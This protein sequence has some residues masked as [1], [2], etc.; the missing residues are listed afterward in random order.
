MS[1]KKNIPPKKAAGKTLPLE[2]V[3]AAKNDLTRIALFLGAAV[4][5][6]YICFINAFKADFTNWD[7]VQYVTESTL[8]KSLHW[9]NIKT[10]FT[11]RSV[12]GNYH[13][14][15]VLSLALDYHSGKLD[16]H[17]FHTTSIIIHLLN[18][19]LVFLFIQLLVKQPVIS[20]IT[21][22]LFGISPMH[23]ESVA[24]VAERKDVLYVFFYMAS[25][26]A[27]LFYLK[28]DKRKIL[29]IVLAF[30]LFA[31]SLLSKAQAVMLPF[32]L[33]GIDYFKGRKFELKIILEK[34]PFFL[35]A[36]LMGVIAVV[37]QKETGAIK[38]IPDNTLLERIAFAGYSFMAYTI[39]LIY[40]GSLSAYYPYPDRPYSIIYIV[41]ALFAIVLVSLVIKNYKNKTLVL[42]AGFYV[43]NIVLLLQLLPVGGAMMADRYSYLCSVGLFFI[44]GKYAFDLLENKK[45]ASFK[46]ALMAIMIGYGSYLAYGARE[47]TKVWNNSKLLWA[48]VLKQYQNAPI[49]YNQLGSYYQKHKSLDTALAYFNEAIRLKPLF[50]E[51]LTNRSDIFR[52]RGD[53]KQAIADCDSAI[54]SDVNYTAAYM[55]RGIAYCFVGK[56]DDALR[57]FTFVVSKKA[58]EASLY[59]NRGN[60]YDMK[61]KIDSAFNDYS[62]A[63]KLD[64]E[65]ADAYFSRGRTYVKMQKYKEA[66]PD[67]D[68]AIQL[69]TTS[70]NVYLYRSQAYR[71]LGNYKASLDDAMTARKLGI[72]I[73]E[74]YISDLKKHLG[75]EGK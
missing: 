13:P 11:T 69:S 41:A 37:A 60:L 8:I 45:L 35:L 71:E 53:Y 67:L 12:M 44:I 52:V 55:N 61:G 19:A 3:N 10:I 16:P 66:I 59:C 70:N 58:G 9:D 24:W 6:T 23:V 18:V 57:D 68:M 15:A 75:T 17:T 73:N 1:Q 56:Y 4:L 51:A 32:V 62:T 49:P 21:A 40:P 20:F 65:Y 63:I 47:R 64:P 2:T 22:L 27:Y 29:F 14:L 5:I 30:F 25:L 50:T 38:E 31:C 46:Y 54:R 26:I 74:D 28:D 34:I 43:M 36:L 7:D 72:D 33:L 39:K 42:G 48:N